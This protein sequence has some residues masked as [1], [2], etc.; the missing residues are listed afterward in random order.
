MK[1]VMPFSKIRMTD[2]PLV[3]GKTASLG[4]MVS[5]GL[6]V[7]DGFAITADAYRYFVSENKLDGQIRKIIKD[8][9]IKKISELKKAGSA[10]RE[11]IRHS[12]FPSDLESQILASYKELGS[13]FVAVRSSATAEDLPDASFAGEQ[14]SYLNID[15]KNLLTR[16][17]DCFSSLFT[18]RAISYREDKKFDHFKVYLSVAVQKQV[19]SKSS[20]VMFTI[21]PDNGN[22]NFIV[23]NSSYGLG[24]YIVQGR[25]TPDEF[26]IFKKSGKLIEKNLGKKTVM[27]I[28]SIFGVKQKT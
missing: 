6:P 27:E 26:R 25:V 7:P 24:D 19:F 20:G 22:E 28:R 12:S 8:T 16:I 18:D 23:I 9:D 4:E 13:R 1:Y 2:V 21:D 5:F 15:H 11:L 17:K 14:E 3:G 10:I